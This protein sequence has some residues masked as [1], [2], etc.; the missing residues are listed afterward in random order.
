M[1]CRMAA[2]NA[3]MIPK[4]IPAPAENPSPKATDHGDTVTSL[5]MLET[6]HHVYR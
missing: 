4:M 3:G 1:G 2:L 6:I 5:Q